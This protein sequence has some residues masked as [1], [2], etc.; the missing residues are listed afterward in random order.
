[1][2]TDCAVKWNRKPSVCW[3]FWYYL[4]EMLSVANFK[5]TTTDAKGSTSSSSC[6]EFK[7]A[8]AGSNRLGVWNGFD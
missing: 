8:R 2:Q 7:T 5:A 4:R 6:D 3:T 1:M